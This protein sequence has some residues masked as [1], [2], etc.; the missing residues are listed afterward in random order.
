MKI[1]AVAF[2]E[3]WGGSEPRPAR[4]WLEELIRMTTER[5]FY[6]MKLPFRFRLSRS[7]KH[8]EKLLD[9]EFRQVLECRLAAG[10]SSES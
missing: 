9:A 4:I 1:V 3:D 2:A 6:P 8:Y 7:I 10:A 5:I